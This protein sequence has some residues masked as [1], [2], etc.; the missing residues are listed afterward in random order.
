MFG[1]LE[2]RRNRHEDFVGL[3]ATQPARPLPRPLTRQAAAIQEEPPK[4]P[5]D[6]M[7]RMSRPGSESLQLDRGLARR[8][9]S[10]RNVPTS[11][12]TLDPGTTSH[13]ARIWREAR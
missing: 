5:V 2:D 3:I 4:V 13:C 11:G 8:V 1:L 7:G 9:Y 6:P 12:L 10:R